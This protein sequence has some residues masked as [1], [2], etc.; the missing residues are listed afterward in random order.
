M[1]QSGIP[2][3]THQKGNVARHT[4]TVI[5]PTFQIKTFSTELKNHVMV[6]DF[7][8]RNWFPS[9]RRAKVCIIRMYQGLKTAEQ[10]ASR[11]ERRLGD[12]SKK[13]C[14]GK[15]PEFRNNNVS[16]K[17]TGLKTEVR[18]RFS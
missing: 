4:D 14:L 5:Y 18:A 2:T 17:Q 7:V 1:Q 11:Y 8:K 16:E 9:Q 10:P 15:Y 6:M 12:S 13:E 3:K